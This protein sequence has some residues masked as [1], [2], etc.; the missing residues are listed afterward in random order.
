MVHQAALT[1]L[2]AGGVVAGALSAV[3]ILLWGVASVPRLLRSW[4]S[5]DS[6]AARSCSR[7]L[8]RKRRLGMGLPEPAARCGHLTI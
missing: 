6:E 8:M 4:C 1:Y 7:L 5:G 3:A 2:A